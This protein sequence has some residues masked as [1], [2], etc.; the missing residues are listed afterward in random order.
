MD[1]RCFVCNEN[2][3]LQ[4]DAIQHLK[5]EHSIQDRSTPIECIVA[6]CTLKYLSFKA[7]KLHLNK[8]H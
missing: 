3:E 6:V 5:I 1:Y 4:N 8:S 7:L 2:F